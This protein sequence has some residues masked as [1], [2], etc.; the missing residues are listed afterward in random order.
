MEAIPQREA[1]DL[2]P[3]EWHC[4]TDPDTLSERLSRRRR[5]VRSHSSVPGDGNGGAVGVARYL[6]PGEHVI[7]ATH[8]HL[9]VL[10]SAVAIWLATVAL[11]LVGGLAS[12]TYRGFYLGQA[13]AA[14]SLAGTAFLG[15]RVWQWWVAR[16]VLT[17]DRVLL[18]EGVL[19]RRVHGVPLGSVLDTTYHRTLTGRLLGYG[20]L[21][22]NLSGRPGLRKLTSLPRP[23]YL[24]H[25]VMVLTS[26]RD[27]MGPS[28]LGSR[29]AI[30]DTRL[31]GGESHQR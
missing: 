4:P 21:D 16:Y 27:V 1:D 15:L 25:L 31:G 13:G 10:N 5:R 8:R 17:N 7:Y 24:Y 2:P 23:D 3:A 29:R 9:V 22:L 14:V 19:S 30:E 28:L 12:R 11:G 26:V 20:D 18:L 6:S